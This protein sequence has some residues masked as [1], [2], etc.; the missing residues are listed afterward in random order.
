[1]RI[2]SSYPRIGIHKRRETYWR[3]EL[4]G[5]AREKHSL[6]IS[7]PEIFTNGTALVIVVLSR[8]ADVLQFSPEDGDRKLLRNVGIY[9]AVHM[10]P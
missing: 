1:M 8:S 9:Q 3:A 6:L 7:V 10:A 5:A 4:P 2:L